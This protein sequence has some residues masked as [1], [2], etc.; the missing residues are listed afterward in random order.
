MTYHQTENLPSFHK[1]RDP[2]LGLRLFSTFSSDTSTTE[3]ANLATMYMDLP[4]LWSTRLCRSGRPYGG[5]KAV[6]AMVGVQ[7]AEEGGDDIVGGRRKRA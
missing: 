6:D 5:R 2:L 3:Q 4:M 1:R 7:G